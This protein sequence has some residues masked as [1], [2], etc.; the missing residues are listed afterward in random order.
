MIEIIAAVVTTIDIVIVHTLLQ[1][2]RGRFMI[3]L[4][5]TF[6]NMLLPLIGFYMGEWTVHFFEGWGPLLS[7]VLIGLVGLHMLLDDGEQP[8]VMD[9]ISPFFLALLVSIDAFTVSV[10][11]GMMQ[12]N[13]WLFIFV[14]GFFS[15]VFSIIALLSTGRIKLING[16]FIRRVAGIVFIIIGVM[17][18]I[19]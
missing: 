7:G 4:W 16:T 15:F 14:S 3:A 13:K 8:S 10:T 12:L 11:F 5:T 6:L 9:K 18:F 17:S 19:F 1:L 2:R